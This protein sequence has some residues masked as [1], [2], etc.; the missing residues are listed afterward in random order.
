MLQLAQLL[1]STLRRGSGHIRGQ[2]R[3]PHHPDKESAACP[4][5]PFESNLAASPADFL[6]NMPAGVPAFV[7]GQVVQ[8]DRRKSDRADEATLPPSPHRDSRRA[9]RTESVDAL[10]VPTFGQPTQKTANP[11][12]PVSGNR[13]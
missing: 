11:G 4:Q 1:Q 9:A 3:S 12:A 2:M 7:P 8:T 5:F 13:G 10:R 6:G